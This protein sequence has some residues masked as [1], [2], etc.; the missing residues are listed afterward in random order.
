MESAASW[1]ECLLVR[2]LLRSAAYSSGTLFSDKYAPKLRDA[3]YVPADE[4]SVPQLFLG[5]I[6][7]VCTAHIDLTIVEVRFFMY[8]VIT[9]PTP[10]CN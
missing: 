4:R 3:P 5:S 10:A 8:I 7:E 1:L 6:Y 2:G 9:L